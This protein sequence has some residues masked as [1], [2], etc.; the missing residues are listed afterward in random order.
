MW[1]VDRRTRGQGNMLLVVE[2]RVTDEQVRGVTEGK[3]WVG[4][5]RGIGWGRKKSELGAEDVWAENGRGVEWGWDGC[6]LGEEGK[7][8]GEWKAC[9]GEEYFILM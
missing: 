2:D 9:E 8:V 5:R 3:G 6:G 7:W 1:Q 4:D